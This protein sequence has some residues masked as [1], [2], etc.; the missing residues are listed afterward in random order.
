MEASLQDLKVLTRC[1]TSGIAN[2]FLSVKMRGKNNAR[3]NTGRALFLVVQ[4]QAF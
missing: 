3:P 1:L 2:Y 4:L